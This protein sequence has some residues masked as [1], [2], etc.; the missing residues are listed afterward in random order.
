MKIASFGAQ[1]LLPRPQTQQASMV[2]LAS[3][4]DE[5][6]IQFAGAPTLESTLKRITARLDD[7]TGW[8]V[9]P[10]TD[11]HGS[12]AYG[13]EIAFQ[14]DGKQYVLHSVPMGW[15][16]RIR[17]DAE[18][19]SFLR[20]QQGNGKPK[21]FEIE[22]EQFQDIFKPL[23]EAAVKALTKEV[24]ATWVENLAQATDWSVHELAP[25][26]EW[27]ACKIGDDKYRLAR[28]NHEGDGPK[29]YLS[30]TP[31]G[32]SGSFYPSLFIDKVTYKA[33]KE[34]IIGTAKAELSPKYGL[35]PELGV[36]QLLRDT[37][38]QLIDTRGQ[39][40][41]FTNQ[42]GSG[43]ASDKA[44][45]YATAPNGAS[46][47]LTKVKD[48]GL[49]ALSLKF[50]DETDSLGLL[51]TN[52][53][54]RKLADALLGLLQYDDVSKG[55]GQIRTDAR[56]NIARLEAEIARLQRELETERGADQSYDRIVNYLP[57][58]REKLVDQARQLLQGE[59]PEA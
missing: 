53:E 6:Q 4:V 14:L 19:G 43:K 55:L 39:D 58:G 57:E 59:A 8:D 28:S 54:D 3:A 42:K 52:P 44:Y 1:T 30:R 37:L 2:S 22:E 13:R 17:G 56:Q 9:R 31:D 33:L 11:P 29:Y 15:A 41:R 5:V 16:G 36:N 18:L 38:Q 45:A 27:L 10:V 47:T 46:L 23:R 26:Y 25:D 7:A 20:V 48:S 40:F 35:E 21:T 24:P 32:V 49:T 50:T 51:I 12:T 34:Q